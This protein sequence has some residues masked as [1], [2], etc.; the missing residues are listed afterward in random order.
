MSE[1]IDSERRSP[2]TEVETVE[3]GARPMPGGWNAE[4]AGAGRVAAA[5][6]VDDEAER[7][8]EALCRT[9][10]GRRLAEEE[11]STAEPACRASVGIE[12]LGFF[13]F[14]RS[15]FYKI[16]PLNKIFPHFSLSPKKNQSTC[17]NPL[18]PAHPPPRAP[19]PLDGL[20]RI[21]EPTTLELLL[22]PLLPNP[23]LPARDRAD[24][25]DADDPSELAE[26]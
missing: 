20:R 10:E 14:F 3:M 8:M 1:A 26:K 15:V 19:A 18:P 4:E 5:S 12:L 25:Y 21:G 9:R 6:S 23:T 17:G 2:R 22:L 11:P 7:R 24:E 16:P 13:F